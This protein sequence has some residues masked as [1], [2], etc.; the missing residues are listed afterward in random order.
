MRLSEGTYLGSVSTMYQLLR[1][2]SRSWNVAVRR[3]IQYLRFQELVAYQTGE[4]F[5]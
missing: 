1:R 4:V 3:G 5:S 2:E